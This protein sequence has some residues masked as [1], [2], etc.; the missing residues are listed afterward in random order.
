MLI[1]LIVDIVIM[2][3]GLVSIT[4]VFGYIAYMRSQYESMGYTTA[5]KDDG[6]QILVKKK[7]RWEN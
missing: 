5:I 1:L 7:S 3:I 6:T 2:G 4:F